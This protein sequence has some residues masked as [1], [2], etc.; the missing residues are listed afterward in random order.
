MSPPRHIQ[1][2]TSGVCSFRDDALNP[3]ETGGPREFR[4]QVGWGVDIHV[5]IGE[6]GGGMGCGRVEGRWGG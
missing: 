4:D 2:R 6:W 1:Y 5:K 3:Q